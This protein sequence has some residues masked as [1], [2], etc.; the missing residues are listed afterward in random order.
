MGATGKLEPTG[1]TITV[2]FDRTV[3]APPE[4]VWL[5]LT[6]PKQIE[7]WL[8][9][10]EFEAAEGGKVHL[11]WPGQGEMHG[12]VTKCVPHSELEYS[13]R[14]EA[15]MS[16]LRFELEPAGDGSTLRLLHFG[17]SPEDAPGFGAGWQAHLEAL[18]VVLAGD[19]APAATRDARYNELKPDYDTL[20]ASL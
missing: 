12:S 14:E 7:S 20:V 19:T 18:D 2:R 17:T 15:S 1:P 4:V 13:W 8:A 16:L 11:V 5:A 6:D 3:A 10:A 9:E